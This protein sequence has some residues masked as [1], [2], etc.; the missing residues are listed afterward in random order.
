VKDGGLQF[1]ASA[2]EYEMKV[3]LFILLAALPLLEAAQSSGRVSGRVLTA[4]AQRSPMQL[5]P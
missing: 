3:A 5:S 1:D 2:K 4:T